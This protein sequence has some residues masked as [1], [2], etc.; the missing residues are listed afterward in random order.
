M[1]KILVITKKDGRVDGNTDL[2]GLFSTLRNG[3]Y[4]VTVKRATEKRTIG[5][6]DLIWLW[7]TCIERET[8][9]LKEDVYSYYCKKYLQK[10]IRFGD[11]LERVYETSSRLNTQQMSE[12]MNKIQADAA[13][14]LGIQLPLPSDRY[15]DAFCEKYR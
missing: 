2:S 14:E 7:F 8:G 6:N 3:T 9:T 13:S 11:R 1:A 5:Q 10:T 4:T 15:F 12:F